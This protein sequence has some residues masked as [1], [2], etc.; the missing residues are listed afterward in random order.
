MIKIN[1]TSNW[2]PDYVSNDILNIDLQMLKFA[3]ITHIVFDLDR[4]IVRHGSNRISEEYSHFLKSVRRSG[5]TIMIG[6]NTR[7]DI[8]SL[9]ALFNSIAI[10]PS[11]I[12]YKPLPSFYRRIITQAGTGSEHIAMVG[13]HILNDIIGANRAG[14]TSILVKGLRYNNPLTYRIYFKLVL[15]RVDHSIQQ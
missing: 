5:F 15:R 13:D 4:T 10:A 2:Y 8:S 11:G 14:F 1:H 9:S 12:S 7:R 6:S 3:G